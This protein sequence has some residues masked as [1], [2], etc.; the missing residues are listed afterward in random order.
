MSTDE[1][2]V[3]VVGSGAAGM[4]A[5]LTAA[6]AGARVTLLEKAA[7]IGGTTAVSGGLLWVPNHHRMAELGLSDPPADAIRYIE[8]NAD[9]RGDRALIAHY[10]ERAP[11][12]LRYLEQHTGLRF[13]PVPKYP[14]YHPELPGGL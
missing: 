9:G 1:A 4:A 14:D 8:R 5:A 13:D 10:V 6:V 2:D 7:L 12:M 3:I 11:G